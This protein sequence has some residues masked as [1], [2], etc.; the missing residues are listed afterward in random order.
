MNLKTL[1]IYVV[2]RPWRAILLHTF[3]FLLLTFYFFLA[4]CLYCQVNQEVYFNSGIDKYVKGDYDGSVE[5]FEKTLSVNPQH[6]K[7]KEFLLK[8]FMNPD[9]KNMEQF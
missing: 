5:L 4:N 6:Q 9:L 1:E 2:A 3:N 8:G 7:S